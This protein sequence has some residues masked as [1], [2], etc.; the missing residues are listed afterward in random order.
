MR[1]GC[2]VNVSGPLSIIADCWPGCVKEALLKLLPG[3]RTYTS[4]VPSAGEAFT[5][6]MLTL[7]DVGVVLSSVS[8]VALI[9]EE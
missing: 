8:I 2:H 1:I 7:P 5:M 6:R 3:A 4:A 9:A